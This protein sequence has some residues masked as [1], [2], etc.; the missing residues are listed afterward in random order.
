MGRP[1]LDRIEPKAKIFDYLDYREYLSA[2]Y[3]QLKSEKSKYSYQ[4]FSVDLGLAR[5]NTLWKI[6]KGQRNISKSESIEKIAKALGLSKREEKY[7]NALVVYI[8]TKHANEREE[9]LQRILQLKDKSLTESSDKNLL[10]YFTEWHYPMI[11]EMVGL[12][13]FKGDP[14]WI[15]ENLNVKINPYTVKQA[16]EFLVDINLIEETKDHRKYKQTGGSIQPT[17]E[18]SK[19]SAL[20]YQ[21]RFLDISSEALSSVP[22]EKRDYQSITINISKENFEKTQD[23]MYRAL[24]EIFDLNQGTHADSETCQLN[25]QLFQLTKVNHEENE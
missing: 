2:V 16:L 19:L 9:A 10:R 14:N 18:I 6:I 17:N 20:G 22:D 5:S 1:K 4:Q 8:N 23:I 13:D 11:R 24:Q 12:P 15:V 21:S 3:E 25:Y 7:L